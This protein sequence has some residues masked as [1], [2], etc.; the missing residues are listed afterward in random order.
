[1]IE[2]NKSDVLKLIDLT[3]LNSSDTNDTITTL[4]NKASNKLGH[5]ASV[6][7]YK[8]FIPLA[9]KLL[10]SEIK[11][12]T[13][14]NFPQGGSDLN[15]ALNEL[16]TVLKLGTD[17]IDVVI[18]YSLLLDNKF[19]EVKDFVLAIREVCKHK[20]LKAILETGILKEESLIR[21]SSQLCISSGVDFIKTSTGKV[22]INATLESA[23]YMLEE[24][25][26]SKLPCGFKAA[27]G[28]KTFEVAKNYLLLAK[29]I[30]GN[31]FINPKTFRFGA[32]SL[33]SD[34]VNETGNNSNY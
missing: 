28:I 7:I 3:S 17:E 15:L 2:F 22:E 21:K 19:I 30:L 5:V 29:N 1:M 8:E 14:I 20:V 6:C 24:I 12:T 18:P 33:L 27:G 10:P 13:V 25:K 26:K 4:C 16:E 9:K 31:N 11:V 34:L 23:K 32:S